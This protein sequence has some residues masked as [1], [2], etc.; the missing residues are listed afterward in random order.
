M[1]KINSRILIV[2]DSLSVRSM[3]RTLLAGE[4]HTVVGELASGAQLMQSIDKLH[5]QIVCLDYNL[6]GVNG[7]DLL[8][9]ISEK[10]PAVAVV[11]ITGSADAH[12]ESNAVEAGA[13]G[14]LR[15]PLSMD[16][17][18]R[19]IAQV[20]H[21]QVLLDKA[22]RASATSEVSRPRC[23]AVVADDSVTIRRLL[24][25]IL[26]EIEVKV[27]GE[28]WDGRQ[29][30]ELVAQQ[31]PDIVCLDF[32]MPNMNGLEAMREIRQIAPATKILMISGRSS[33]ETIMQGI[34]SGLNGYILKP[35]Q[36]D[37]VVGAVLKCWSE[38]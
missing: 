35:F 37:R 5:P 36:P 33:R 17:I 29:A 4:G 19:E 27:V 11:M 32:E 12:V 15:K 1:A 10:H 8:H 7:I 20:A 31:R 14:F 21:A 28:A 34:K 13:A 25:A 23:T 26:A 6:P 2:D 30:V 9:Q 24:T 38:L 22:T 16:D 3:L 18:A